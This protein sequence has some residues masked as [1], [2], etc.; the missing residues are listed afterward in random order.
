ME[1]YLTYKEVAEMLKYS[2]RTVEYWVS[3]NKIP[4]IKIGNN[5][6]GVRFARS[7]VEKWIESR[8]VKPSCLR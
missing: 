7:E 3:A 1:N 2:K 5:N 8:K 6:S 4:F